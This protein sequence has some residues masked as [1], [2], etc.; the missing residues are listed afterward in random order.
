MTAAKTAVDRL[1]VIGENI[2]ATRTLSRKGPRIATID[3][4]EVIRFTDPNGTARQI[5]IPEAMKKTQDFEQGRVKHVKVAIDAA[6]GKGGDQDAGLSYLHAMALAQ[7]KA[8][9]RFLDLNVDEIS[10]KPAEQLAAMRW[11]AATIQRLSRSPVAIDSSSVET[12]KAGLEALTGEGPR[13]LLNSASLE[14]LDALD[15]SRAHQARVVVTAAGDKGMPD[16]AQQRIDNASRM[17]EAALARGIQLDDMYV[18][19]LIFPVSVDT[20]FGQHSLDAIRGLRER[21]GPEIHITGGMSNV[22]FGIPER[23][24]INEVF[25]LFTIEAGADSAIMDPVISPLAAVLALD[26]TTP[27]YKLAEDVI[28]DRDRHCRAYLKAWRKGELKR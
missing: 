9:A 19:P 16:G 2:H 20:A 13:P 26:R 6:M 14:R 25:L 17:I 3:G 5:A 15:L 7:E 21:F 18:D 10:V 28:F 12:I 22:S 4:Q 27:A 24:L 23:R 1:I 8:G 11:L